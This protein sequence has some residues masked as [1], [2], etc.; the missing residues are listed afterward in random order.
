EAETVDETGVWLGN[1]EEPARAAP[2]SS[3]HPAAIFFPEDF[4]SGCTFANDYWS[5]RN[6][7]DANHDRTISLRKA[8]GLSVN[9]AFATLASQVGTCEIRDTMSE[10]G[11][12]GA[13][14]EPYGQ[15]PT[16]FVLGSDEASP[17]TVAA[18]YATIAAGGMYCPPVPVTKITDPQGN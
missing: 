18:S 2:G 5:V 6:A 7:E 16:D 11:L 10:M 9:T 15:F 1:P 12:H 4:Q 3:T 13:D 17:L 14:G 8:T